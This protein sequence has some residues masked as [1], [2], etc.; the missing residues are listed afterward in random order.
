M[1]RSIAGRWARWRRRLLRVTF[2]VLAVAV[3]LVALE[4]VL[5][6]AGVLLYRPIDQELGRLN[7]GGDAVRI[8]CVGDSHVYGMDAPPEMSFPSQLERLLNAR[9]RARRYQ[10]V[11]Q[12]V[13][14]FNSS[15]TL[16]RLRE[17]LEGPYEKPQLVLVCVGKNNDH[18]FRDAR[19]WAEEGLGQATPRQQAAHLLEQ[20][21]V[22]QLGKITRRN[23]EAGLNEERSLEF[24]PVLSSRDSTLLHDWLTADFDEMVDLVEQSGGRIAFVSYFHTVTYV[25]ESM[26]AVAADRHVPWIDVQ[27]SMLAVGMMPGLVGET[28]HPNA[29]GYGR[30]ARSVLDGLEREGLIPDPA[31]SR[32]E[33]P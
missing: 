26:Q 20:S 13:P 5:W 9:D 16:N 23:L 28:N 4:C 24:D 1:A 17:I 33:T 6:T 32:S 22:Y 19:F 12:G 25:D 18:N 2:A 3:S 7:E 11:N 21:R 8:L 15:Q 14:G 10:V 29:R 27:W 31:P 30:V